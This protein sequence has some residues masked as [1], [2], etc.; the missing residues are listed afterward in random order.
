MSEIARQVLTSAEKLLWEKKFKEAQDALGEIDFS[1][2]SPEDK[3]L[4]RRLRAEIDLYAGKYSVD[5]DIRHALAYYRKHHDEINIAR[6]KFL[7]GWRMVALGRH[8]DAREILMESATIYKRKRDP[9]NQA[10]V[11][12][13]LSLVSLQLGDIDGA[14]EYLSRGREIYQQERDIVRQTIV[15]INL[16]TLNCYAGRISKSLAIFAKIEPSAGCLSEKDQSSYYLQRAIPHAMQ[17]DYAGAYQIIRRALPLIAGYPRATAQY[18]ENLARIHLLSDDFVLAEEALAKGL[19]IALDIAAQS[20]LVSQIKRRLAEACLG[21]G[22]YDQARQ[23]AHEALIVAENIRE[24]PEAG[25]CRRIFARLE[26]ED[27]QENAARGWFKKAIDIFDQVGYQYE[28]AVTRYQAGASGLYQTA[29]NQALLYLARDYFE[30][31]KIAPYLRKIEQ[32]FP[33]SRVLPKRLAEPVGEPPTF[34]AVNKQVK[35][36]LDLARRTAPS[37]LSILL[38]GPTGSGKDLLAEYIHFYSGRSGRFVAVNSAAIPENMIEAELFGYGRG[39]FTGADRDKIGLIEEA[40]N[41]T[42]YLNEIADSSPVFQAKLLDALERKAIRRLGETT[43]RGVAFRLIAATNHEIEKMVERGSFRIDLYHRLN[44][45]GL[46]LPPLVQRPEDI[47]ALV[48]YFLRMSGVAV[49]E[50]ANREA[51]EHLIAVMGSRTWPG[52]IRQL[53]SEIARLALL[54]RADL[55]QLVATLIDVIP[56]ERERLALVLEKTDWNRRETARLL[57][58]SDMTIR[59]WIR[60]FNIAEPG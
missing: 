41:G 43:E 30:K 6:V 40:N 14:L 37:E 38:T 47:P 46:R 3:A 35:H 32:F 31:E 4:Y 21:Q 26:L 39:A 48:R 53:K 28:L 29:E 7:Q 34:I 49:D 50:E 42:L 52:N 45:I 24:R 17:G 8:F 5:E 13:Q 16:G 1:S 25:A 57:G 11:F 2:I 56:D 18:Y 19:G 15:E 22:K 33:S 44:E 12:N 51:L 27:G 10:R 60:K 58:V 59:R 36:I 23:H 20:A 54:A 55:S 9:Q